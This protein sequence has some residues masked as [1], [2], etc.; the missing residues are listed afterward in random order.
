MYSPMM[1]NREL[2]FLT[3]DKEKDI[4]MSIVDKDAKKDVKPM[5]EQQPQRGQQVGRTKICCTLGPKT[6]GVEALKSMLK[7]GM[8]IAR[9]NINYLDNNKD[10][11]YQ[12][13]NN[14]EEATSQTG[15]QCATMVEL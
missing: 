1:Q 10:L 15:L 5:I 2:G 14:L 9:I 3:E 7:A 6:Y 12:I 4:L 13:L 11:L 8:N